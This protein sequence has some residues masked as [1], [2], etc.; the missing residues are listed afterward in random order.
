MYM[1]VQPRNPDMLVS[2]LW[3]GK[4]VCTETTMTGC[5]CLPRPS[6]PWIAM[7]ITRDQFT[8][9]SWKIGSRFSTFW[10]FCQKCSSFSPN[11]SKW[12]MLLPPKKKCPPY[13]KMHLTQSEKRKTGNFTNV[14]TGLFLECRIHRCTWLIRTGK[15][16]L[17]RL[18]NVWMFL[19]TV[20][21]PALP[22]RAIFSM[23]GSTTPQSWGWNHTLQVLLGFL[24]K[25][26]EMTR[27]ALV[28]GKGPCF[29]SRFFATVASLITRRAVSAWVFKS[30]SVAPGDPKVSQSYPAQIHPCQETPVWKPLRNSSARS[31]SS[32]LPSAPADVGRPRVEEEIGDLVTVARSIN[33]WCRMR[34]DGCTPVFSQR[35]VTKLS[36]W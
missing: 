32:S 31:A 34:A 4:M 11:S 9:S 3:I 22:Q 25:S 19:H 17:E 10:K 7:G 26:H 30:V 18:R 35:L 15:S 29:R 21:S 24:Y 8:D 36:R 28:A 23:V 1:C 16:L 20:F 2:P 12:F 13:P 6:S 33:I 5:F 27:Q 14:G